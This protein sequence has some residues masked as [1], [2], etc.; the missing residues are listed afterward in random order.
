MQKGFL[1]LETVMVG[2]FLLTASL[3]CFSF[4]MLDRQR[5][6]SDAS[7]AAV[8]LAKEQVARIVSDAEHYRGYTGEIPWLGGGKPDIKNLNGRSYEVQTTMKNADEGH[9]LREVTVYVRWESAGQR[10]EEKFR[11]LVDCGG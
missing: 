2:F 9:K 1:L 7:H 8:Y 3:V 4:G 10:R 11:K 5:A 6:E